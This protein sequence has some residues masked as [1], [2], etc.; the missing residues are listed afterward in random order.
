MTEAA[1][2]DS[3]RDTRRSQNKSR[4]ESTLSRRIIVSQRNVNWSEARIRCG[5]LRQRRRLLARLVSGCGFRAS[6]ILELRIVIHRAAS[7]SA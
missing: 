3:I 5:C 6:L 2:N 1:E 4:R 7:G